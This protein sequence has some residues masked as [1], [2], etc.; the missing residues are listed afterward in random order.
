MWL[1]TIGTAFVV[2][3]SIAVTGSALAEGA[4]PSQKNQNAAYCLQ[5][6]G[7][8]PNCTFASMAECTKAKAG[9]DKCIQNPSRATTGAGSGMQSPATKSA[10]PASR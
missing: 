5:K 8:S 3:G 2:A 1:K 10:P 7:Q 6:Q 9:T 4:Q